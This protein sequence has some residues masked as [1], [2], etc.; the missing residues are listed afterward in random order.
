MV[1]T[2][3]SPA[4]AYWATFITPAESLAAAADSPL[5]SAKSVMSIQLAAVT[6]FLG[7]A[8]VPLATV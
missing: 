7:G 8:V 3:A 1:M 2:A 4:K 6:A 5:S